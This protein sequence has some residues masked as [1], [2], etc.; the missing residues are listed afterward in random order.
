M[1]RTESVARA[2]FLVYASDRCHLLNLVSVFALRIAS[3]IPISSSKFFFR[4]IMDSAV[5]LNGTRKR[6]MSHHDIFLTSSLFVPTGITS[7]LHFSDHSLPYSSIVLDLRRHR[8]EALCTCMRCH[9]SADSCAYVFM[10][11]SVCASSVC[12]THRQLKW[13]E[14]LHSNLHSPLQELLTMFDQAFWHR[15]KGSWITFSISELCCTC[16]NTCVRMCCNDSPASRS[17]L[18][19]CL[20]DLWQQIFTLQLKSEF[21]CC[22]ALNAASDRCVLWHWGC[23]VRH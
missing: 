2:A 21:R 17:S 18:I 6:P 1:S 4:G 15:F 12:H 14:L 11:V 23:L 13:F 3:S 7:L 10:L 19:S 22:L 9:T 5:W 8:S 16:F 20:L